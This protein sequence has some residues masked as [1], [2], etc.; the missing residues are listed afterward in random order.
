MW[1]SVVAGRKPS[2]TDFPKPKHVPG[3]TMT[4]HGPPTQYPWQPSHMAT[5]QGHS[6]TQGQFPSQSQTYSQGQGHTF[7]QGYN[8]RYSPNQIGKSPSS[9][10]NLGHH[11][12]QYQSPGQVS[13]GQQFPWPQ[14]HQG[15]FYS[16]P[17]FAPLS[18]S[19]NIS[20]GQVLNPNF[21]AS[22]SKTSA[23]SKVTFSLTDSESS[24]STESGFS[25]HIGK[26]S[27]TYASV[28]SKCKHALDEMQHHDK[29]ESSSSQSKDSK[30]G[31][32]GAQRPRGYS[33]GHDR[34]RPRSNYNYGNEKS[35]KGDSK[36]KKPYVDRGQYYRK[37]G[38]AHQGLQPDRS[39]GQRGHYRGQRGR[40]GRGR[41]F[42]HEIDLERGHRSEPLL[43]DEKNDFH[44]N[45]HIR[46]AVSS[47]D[48]P[49]NRGSSEFSFDTPEIQRKGDKPEQSTGAN[50]ADQ[51]SCET[52]VI[53]KVD[54]MSISAE[55]PTVKE[56][57]GWVFVEHK[58]PKKKDHSYHDYHREHHHQHPN[59]RRDHN[60]GH[61][62]PH[63]GH[64]NDESTF[65]E[66]SHS[67]RAN[68][69]RHR[70]QGR[71]YFRGKSQ[72]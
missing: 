68:H 3:T 12:N 27:E 25:E 52:D 71:G 62:R 58:Q 49:V 56:Q 32:H 46:R 19:E 45:H 39:R 9:P 37:D 24:K 23:K 38:N 59:D 8:Q 5:G 35:N 33:E 43:D 51:V 16:Q 40:R 21:P 42:Y 29:N 2:L 67:D 36:F 1:A 48:K 60:R 31:K 15:H 20:P 26:S 13:P 50:K 63:R 7:T 44:D 53:N 17:N 54:S 66:R 61:N 18:E 47:P 64:D 10:G 11:D 34:N 30:C 57:S 4:L 6:Y 14:G 22:D 41:D 70:G 28:C 72:E 55:S 65:R 69:H